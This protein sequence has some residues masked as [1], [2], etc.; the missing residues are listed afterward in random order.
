MIRFLMNNKGISLVESVAVMGIMGAVTLFM[1]QGQMSIS[2]SMKK[3][4]DKNYKERVATNIVN[5]IRDNPKI[6]QAHFRSYSRAEKDSL[7]SRQRMPLAW[8]KDGIY[9]KE[10]C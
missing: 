9:K 7:L 5:S 10:E 2:G 1:V 4:V 6:F 8:D 3:L